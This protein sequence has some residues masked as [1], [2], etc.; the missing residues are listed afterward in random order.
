M[1]GQ[2]HFCVDGTLPKLRRTAKEP[3]NKAACQA[4][5]DQN[6]SSCTAITRA[7]LQ[8][9]SLTVLACR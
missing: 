9:G 7:C 1:V 3:A 4:L 5:A 8:G 6:F 2:Q